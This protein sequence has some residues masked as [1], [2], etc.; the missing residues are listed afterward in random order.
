MKKIYLL[1]LPFLFITASYTTFAQIGQVFYQTFELSEGI[2]TLKF[3]PFNS[4]QF[5]EWSSD[6]LMIETSV[7]LQDCNQTRKMVLPAEP[8]HLIVEKWRKVGVLNTPKKND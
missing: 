5:Q 2:D 7:S 8:Y 4:P 3:L 6:K 1:S